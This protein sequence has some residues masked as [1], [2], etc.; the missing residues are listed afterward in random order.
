MNQ[1]LDSYNNIFN[2]KNPTSVRPTLSGS[3]QSPSQH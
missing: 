2:V 3:L 1:L